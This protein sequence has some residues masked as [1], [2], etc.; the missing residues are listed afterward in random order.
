MNALITVII[1][2]YNSY[3]ELYRAISSVFSQTIDSYELIVVDD[4]SPDNSRLIDVISKFQDKRLSL[5]EHSKN[6][7]GSAAR[8]TGILNSSTKYVALLDCD[9]FWQPEH[10]SKCLK[11]INN[12]DNQGVF[13]NLNVWHDSTGASKSVYKSRNR[14][15]DETPADFILGNGI[16][17][18]SS[19]F[20]LREAAT[21]VLFDERL[22]RHQDFDFFIR[23][24]NKYSFVWLDSYEV[25]T[26]WELNKPRN[27]NFTSCILFYKKHKNELKSKVKNKYLL[28]M[29]YTSH[30]S[31]AS[32]NVVGFYI[33]ELRAANNPL[34]LFYLLTFAPRFLWK[35]TIVAKNVVRKYI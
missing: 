2:H 8:N 16:A 13:S 25:V 34:S 5:I 24:A 10:L 9:D 27:V 15:K 18:T 20:L 3:D 14:S 1:P 31:N 26:L 7:N 11:K 21:E 32:K 12:T 17:Q 30:Y 22:Y 4:N 23:Y 33:D 19:Y 35:A 29:L 28:K 6:L